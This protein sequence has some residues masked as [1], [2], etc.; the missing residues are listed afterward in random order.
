MKQASVVQLI[1]AYRVRG[2]LRAS[3]DPL[4]LEEIPPYP[5]L[6]LSSYGLTVWDLDRSFVTD[7]QWIVTGVNERDACQKGEK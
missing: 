3:L 7:L 5:E 6:E 1:R 4:G 2:H